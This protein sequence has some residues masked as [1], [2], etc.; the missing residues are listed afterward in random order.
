MTPLASCKSRAFVVASSDNVA[1]L[2]EDV[3]A[4]ME[5]RLLGEADPG[6][7]ILTRETI[8]A[9]HKV[10]LTQIKPLEPVIKYGYRIGHATCLISPGAWVHLHNCASDVD[11]RSNTLDV[12]T[13]APQDTREAY[14]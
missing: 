3:P 10:A 13:G 5:V 2:L 9:A 12:Q 1:T 14:E 8:S 11:E 7:S 6:R 4:G